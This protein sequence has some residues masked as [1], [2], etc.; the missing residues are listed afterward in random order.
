LTIDLDITGGL[1]PD[2]ATLTFDWCTDSGAV[3]N[4]TYNIDASENGSLQISNI[5]LSNTGSDSQFTAWGSYSYNV[6][7][8]NLNDPTALYVKTSTLTYTT[9]DTTTRV[10]LDFVGVDNACTNDQSY[11]DYCVKNCSL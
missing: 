2:S 10:V 7:T 6:T 5:N 3:G 8:A 1:T 4:A 11:S 9:S